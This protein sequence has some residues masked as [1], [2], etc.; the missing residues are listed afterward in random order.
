MSSRSSSLLAF[1][2]RYAAGT[3]MAAAVVGRQRGPAEA[4]EQSRGPDAPICP[5]ARRNGSGRLVFIGSGN[6]T[7]TPRPQC[8]LQDSE[9]QEW[10]ARCRVSIQ[11]MVGSPDCNRNYRGNPAMLIQYTGSDGEAR[12][13]QIDA[14]KTFRENLLRW[15]PRFGVPFVDAVIITHCHADA[16]MGIDDLRAVQPLPASSVPGQAYLAVKD[17]AETPVFVAS[18]HMPR[19]RAMFP[20]LMPEAVK[21]QTVPRFVARLQWNEVEDFASFTCP[22]GLEVMLL[23]VQHGRD[24]ICAAFLFGKKEKVGY[25]SDVSAVPAATM[26][27]LEK[28][29]LDLLV[30]DCLLE[31][32]HPVH[33]GMEDVLPLVRKLRPRRT[34]LVGMSDS[35]EHHETNARLRTLLATEGL[36]IQLAHDGLHVDMM[37]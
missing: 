7:G 28:A 11:A 22:G 14:G 1:G 5:A 19:M 31:T 9:D 12:N 27:M 36:D 2:Y 34:L 35:F 8:I 33:F 10:A 29:P 30:L 17:T 23:P 25:L 3:A 6:S 21:A 4:A 13:V 26:A 20:Y 32:S 24:Y 37:L 18:R 15:Y 16:T